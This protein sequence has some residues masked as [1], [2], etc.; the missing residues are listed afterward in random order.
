MKVLI[1]IVLLTFSLH[2]NVN[3]V[4][5]AGIMDNNSAKKY[6]NKLLTKEPE[7]I[8]CILKLAGVYLKSGEILKGYKYIA[9]AYKINPRAVKHSEISNILSYALEI[10]SLEKRAKQS[11]N[12]NLWN[13]L[14]DSFFDMGVY[15][16]TTNAYEK[17]L[18]IDK[19]QEQ[20]ALK[21]ALSYKNSNQTFKAI[22]HLK[23]LLMQNEKNFYAKYYL[24]KIFR[25]S[26]GDEKLAETYFLEAKELLEEQKD[27]F[28][29][30]QYSSFRYDITSELGK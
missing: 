7:N 17:S 2:A 23:R 10:T 27:D 28:T 14:G 19:T 24:G 15:S 25:Y 3:V 5:K 18:G 1:F 13:E 4:C 8:E 26:V 6:I 21:L 11:N 22:E 30:D 12:K 20:I 16:E 9:R 29:S